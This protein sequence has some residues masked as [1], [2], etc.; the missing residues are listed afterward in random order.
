[1]LRDSL[2]E[3]SGVTEVR[4]IPVQL[5]SQADTQGLILFAVSRA[6]GGLGSVTYNMAS[7][8]KWKWTRIVRRY[9]KGDGL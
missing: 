4:T 3:N 8:K 6:I 7:W 1:M 5:L 9:A 2:G